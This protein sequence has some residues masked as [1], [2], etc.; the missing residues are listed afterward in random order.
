MRCLSE[1]TFKY[2]VYMF[3]PPHR[4]VFYTEKRIADADDSGLV[5]ISG[6]LVLMC[7]FFNSFCV[8][9]IAAG[10]EKCDNML[11]V[12]YCGGEWCGKCTQK[13][14]PHMCDDMA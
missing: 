11:H 6:G 8:I 14:I 3:L 10:G 9:Y 2:Y 5:F 7:S 1:C 12:P 4:V 13:C